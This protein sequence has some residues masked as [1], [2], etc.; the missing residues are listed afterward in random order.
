[1][2]LFFRS[3]ESLN[4]WCEKRA[5]PRRPS[6]TLPQLWKMG[7]AWYADRL[8][9]TARRPNPDEIR[10]IF[11]GIGLSDPFWDPYADYFV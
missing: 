10:A 3:E 1:M 7:V 9:R 11:S 8:S 4:D 2:M 6:A 5:Y